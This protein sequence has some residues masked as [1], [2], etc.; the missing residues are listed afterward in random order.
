MLSFSVSTGGGA[1]REQTRWTQ[2]SE[3]I[4][5]IW[6]LVIKSRWRFS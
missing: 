2:N 3:I 1:R 4:D 5:F 6:S